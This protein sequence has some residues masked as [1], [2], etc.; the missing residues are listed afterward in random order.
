MKFSIKT[1]FSADTI[2]ECDLDAS[3]DTQSSASKLGA[4]VKAAYLGGANLSGADLGGAYLRG[5]DLRGADLSGADL[6]GADLSD[7]YLGGADLRGANLGGAYLG[8]AYL[9][10]HNE[11]KIIGNHP[12]LQIGPLGSRNDVLIIFMTDAGIYVR[13]GCF[14]DTLQNFRAAV[15]K[16]H[17]DNN[18]GK[19]YAAAMVMIEA[20]F[21][22][23]SDEQ[24]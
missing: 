6:R 10:K 21:A 13:A 15:S 23:W 17:G 9:G 11:L 12:V 5:A 18:H 19:E 20:Y 24:T 4:A 7:A 1:R 22:I 16:E 3:F 8:G 2:F 14:F